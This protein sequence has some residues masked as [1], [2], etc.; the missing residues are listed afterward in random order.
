[1][2]CDTYVGQMQHI[3]AE[4]AIAATAEGQQLFVAV[5]QSP[6]VSTVNIVHQLIGRLN[7]AYI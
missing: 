6:S 4:A 5:T 3:A 2:Y 1:M 7:V